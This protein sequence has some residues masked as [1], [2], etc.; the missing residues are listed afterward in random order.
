MVHL[1]GK[2]IFN[3]NMSNKPQLSSFKKIKKLNKIKLNLNKNK[4]NKYT[5]YN[6]L[7]RKQNEI[8]NSLP[9]IHV[10]WW[11]HGSEYNNVSRCIRMGVT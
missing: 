1:S 11:K 4:L 8:T 5:V 6:L 7:I 3:P 10:I 9:R 2:N